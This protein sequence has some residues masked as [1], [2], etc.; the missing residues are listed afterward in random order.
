[1][2]APN[3]LSNPPYFTSLPELRIPSQLSRVQTLRNTQQ[4]AATNR[5]CLLVSFPAERHSKLGLRST[6]PGKSPAKHSPQVYRGLR[7][8][9]AAS[10]RAIANSNRIL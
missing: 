2:G 5:F 3:K 10:M 9:K 8:R 4:D 6:K 1:M 7:F